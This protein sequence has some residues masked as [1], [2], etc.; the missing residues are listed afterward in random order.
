M[1]Q[2]E[3][4]AWTARVDH[5]VAE[6]RH[7]P[8]PA[9]AAEVHRLRC[10]FEAHGLQPAAAVAR[11]METVVARGDRGTLVQSWATLLREAATCG[12]SDA[13]ARDAFAA[14]CSVRFT[15]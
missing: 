14:A 5:L 10:G 11:A 8:A 2:A 7:L 13:A 1:T 12:R 9:L 3:R 6:C 4:S 15:G